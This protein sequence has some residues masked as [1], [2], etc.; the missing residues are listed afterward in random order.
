MLALP[1]IRLAT[2]H[3]APAIAEMS[4]RQIE[5]G[6]EW[7]WTPARVLACMADAATNVA[8]MPHADSIA[9]FGVMQYRDEGA[10]LALFAVHPMHRNKGLG[11][12]LMAWLEKPARTAGLVRVRLE[13]RADNAMAIAFYK[14]LGF[15]QRKLIAGYYSGLIDAVAL[16]KRFF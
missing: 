9:G 4:R 5:Q 10:H 1:T 2:A 16:E 8:V 7:S 14:K 3:D 15:S 11:R 13:A 12:Q 6:L